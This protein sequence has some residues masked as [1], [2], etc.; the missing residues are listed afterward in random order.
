M[1]LS[2]T[3]YLPASLNANNLK[4]M[5]GLSN[6]RY[7]SLYRYLLYFEGCSYVAALIIDM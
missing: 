2:S 1:R 7:Q 6:V 4:Q 5:S 3:I